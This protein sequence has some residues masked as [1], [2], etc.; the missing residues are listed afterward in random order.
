MLN[1]RLLIKN[2]LSHNDENTFYDKKESLDLNTHEG[3]TKFL[4]HVCAL[5]NSNPGNNS[6]LIIGVTDET[7]EIKGFEL[8][9]DSKVQNLV[10]ANLSNPPLVK[11]E[12]IYF[13]HLSKNKA[14]GLLTITPESNQTAFKKTMGKV[15]SG[16][17]YYRKG[18]NSIPLDEDFSIDPGNKK[19]VSEIENFSNVSFKQLLDDVFDFYNTWGKEYD[20]QYL[21]FKDQFILCWAGYRT[22]FNGKPLLS[23]VDIRIVNE[24]SRIFYS[25]D[26]RVNVFISDSEFNITEYV[27]LGFDN[28]HKLYPLEKTSL[29][30]DDN[31]QYSLNTEVIFKLPE[32]DG[33]QID[34]LYEKA[35]NIENKLKNGLPISSIH[36]SLS[37]EELANYFLISYFN[38]IDRA[39][40][41]L[42]NSADYLEGAAA[43]CR[44]ECMRILE[45]A[46]NSNGS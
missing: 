14:V 22:D 5:S 28:N 4:K 26:Q 29:S 46:E 13:P 45:K 10:K 41:D 3:K 36:N 43:Q 20:P 8:V 2:L 11:Y 35:K 16:T 7:N 15:F 6:Y 31:G 34:N 23:E 21:V 33:K 18:S 17:C 44:S 30:F 12:N 40:S 38:G 25:A 9:D 42:I 24:G 37:A 19:A 39:K 32:F 1:K 27:V